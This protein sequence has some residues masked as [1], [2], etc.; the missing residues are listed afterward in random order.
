MPHVSPAESA[1]KLAMRKGLVQM[2][3]RV[4]AAGVVTNPLIPVHVWDI[5]MARLVA[6][7]TLRIG[8]MGRA[9]VRLWSALGNRLVGSTACGAGLVSPAVLLGKRWNRKNEQSGQS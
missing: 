6:V 1:G 4:A 5:G 9:C 2:V 3:V 8:R 7:V